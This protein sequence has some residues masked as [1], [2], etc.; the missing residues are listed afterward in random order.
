[1][2]AR[3]RLH[4]LT[5]TFKQFLPEEIQGLPPDVNLCCHVLLKNEQ[6]NSNKK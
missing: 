5:F 4:S 3:V 1:M 2:A 6:I